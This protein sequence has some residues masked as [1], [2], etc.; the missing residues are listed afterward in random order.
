MSEDYYCMFGVILIILMMILF[1]TKSYIVHKPYSHKIVGTDLTIFT[2]NAQVVKNKD[3]YMSI[4]V[5]SSASNI[6]LVNAQ[7]W[8][9]NEHIANVLTIVKRGGIAFMVLNRTLNK[10]KDY[11]GQKI[12]VIAITH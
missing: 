6:N 11:R 10:D 2:F 8:I 5:P 3:N 9:Y 1:F 12:T 4:R 7:V